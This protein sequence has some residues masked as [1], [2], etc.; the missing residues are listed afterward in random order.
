MYMYLQLQQES[1]DN[2]MYIHMYVHNIHVD[3]GPHGCTQITNIVA[4][5]FSV[6]HLP[7]ITT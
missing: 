2:Y 4:H 3:D 5:V 7:Y 1:Q 6:E